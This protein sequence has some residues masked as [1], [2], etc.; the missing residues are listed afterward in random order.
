MV[1]WQTVAG[2]Q[3]YHAKSLM[4][5]ASKYQSVHDN[6]EL[7]AILTRTGCHL[8]ALPAV[9]PNAKL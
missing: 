5:L 7:N 1:W 6:D 3:K 9:V 4:V 8:P 2:P